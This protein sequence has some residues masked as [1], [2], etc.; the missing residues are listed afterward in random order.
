MRP[1]TRE[2]MRELDRRAIEEFGIPG[3]VLMENAGRAAAEVVAALAGER[4]AERV[5]ILCG[6][7][8]NGGDGYVVAR[9]LHNRGLAVEVWRL[10]GDPRPGS[11]AATN[12]EVA[13]K[14]GISIRRAE[15]PSALDE[16]RGRLGP[17][18][19]AVDALL[20]TGLA[21]EVREPYLSAIELLDEGLSPVVAIDGPSGLDCNT[22]EVLGASVHAVRTVT[23]GAPKVGF[24]L[25]DGPALVGDLVVAD[26]SIPRELLGDEEPS[27]T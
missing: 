21:G 24:S 17:A 6:R 18:A 15:G 1:R 19:V 26:I 3:I 13:I 20:G 16:I 25:G 11:D 22:G 12:L 27:G 9:H 23:F 14:M 4:S 7:G 8:N 10:G 5:V 2:E